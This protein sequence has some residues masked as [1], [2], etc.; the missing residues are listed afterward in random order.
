MNRMNGQSGTGLPIF[1]IKRDMQSHIATAVEKGDNAA[2]KKMANKNLWDCQ[3]KIMEAIDVIKVLVG[4]IIEF[5]TENK[6]S[7]KRRKYFSH[8]TG[9]WVKIC[10]WVS[11]ILVIM[12]LI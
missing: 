3:R 2:K 10:F 8:K 11:L 5:L 9:K 6:L 7:E 12:G 1:R 4:G